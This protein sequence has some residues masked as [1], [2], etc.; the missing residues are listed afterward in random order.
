MGDGLIIDVGEIAAA[1]RKESE[2]RIVMVLFR[3]TTVWQRFEFDTETQAINVYD[4]VR[5]KM[6]ERSRAWIATGP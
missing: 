2:P 1:V 6:V 3:S 5:E 4:L